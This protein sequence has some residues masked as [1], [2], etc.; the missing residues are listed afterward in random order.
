MAGRRK[1]WSKNFKPGSME[2]WALGYD[3]VLS[4]RF[5][6]LIPCPR[7]LEAAAALVGPL[8]SKDRGRRSSCC[9]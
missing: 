1:S 5:P 2:E 6:R 3:E 8:A 9:G 4:K 7:L